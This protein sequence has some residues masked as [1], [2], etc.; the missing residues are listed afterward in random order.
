MLSLCNLHKNVLKFSISYSPYFY[1]MTVSLLLLSGCQLHVHSLCSEGCSCHTHLR[2]ETWECLQ[3]SMYMWGSVREW[4]LV[5]IL[6]HFPRQCLYLQQYFTKMKQ[7]SKLKYI[8]LLVRNFF[9]R[10]QCSVCQR[11][12]WWSKWNNFTWMTH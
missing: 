3:V 10:C 11:R 12:L 5:F 8:L 9:T 6:R 2:F 7:K 1:L 4:L